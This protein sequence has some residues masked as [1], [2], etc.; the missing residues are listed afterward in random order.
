MGPG[1]EVS[2]YLAY[3]WRSDAWGIKK[4]R[5]V[6]N[7]VGIVCTSSKYGTEKVSARLRKNLEN[8]EK[9]YESDVA[10]EACRSD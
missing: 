8:R 4:F 10:G 2:A 3:C 5:Y 1:V 6:W 7:V 9:T